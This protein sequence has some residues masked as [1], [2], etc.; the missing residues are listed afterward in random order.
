[1]PAGTSTLPVGKTRRSTTGEMMPARGGSG[2]RHTAQ[3]TAAGSRMAAPQCGQ[4]DPAG[5]AAAPSRFGYSCITVGEAGSSADLRL[6]R[7]APQVKQMRSSGWTSA[8]QAGQVRVA[9]SSSGTAA[10]TCSREP[11]VRGTARV[12]GH[13]ASAQ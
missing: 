3:N 10:G 1:M 6:G 8:A 5:G 11:N 7:L 2:S 4:D 13:R 9:M 12:P